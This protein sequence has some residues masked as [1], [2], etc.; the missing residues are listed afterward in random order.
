MWEELKIRQYGMLHHYGTGRIL[1]I[2]TPFSYVRMEKGWRCLLLKRM[3]V[4][5]YVGAVT[6]GAQKDQTNH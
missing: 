4:V 6:L 2:E 5:I 1:E 3:T